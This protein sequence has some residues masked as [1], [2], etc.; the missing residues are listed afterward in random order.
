MKSFTPSVLGLG[1]VTQRSA[2]AFRETVSK[3]EHAAGA[4]G[5]EVF[6]R[7]DHRGNAKH[8]RM[9]LR[10]TELLIFGKPRVST[11][12]IQAQQTAGLDLPLKVLVWRDAQGVVWVTHND[13]AF[14]ALRH[15]ATAQSDTVAAMHAWF[16]AVVRAVTS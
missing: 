2:F 3:L 6:G 4:F 7:I 13:I 12:L 16:D 15:G 11:P 9:A 14:I 5:A 1:L 8:E 10:P